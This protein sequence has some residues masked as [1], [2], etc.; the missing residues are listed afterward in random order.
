MT[1]DSVIVLA[2]GRASRLGGVDKPLLVIDGRTLLQRALDAAAGAHPRIVVGPLRPGLPTDLVWVRETPAFAGP[3]ANSTPEAAVARA[4][5]VA[6]IRALDAVAH[7]TPHEWTLVLA[8]DLVD[9]AAAVA[10]LRAERGA[11]SPQSRG[12]CLADEAG[13]AQWLTGFYRTAALREAAA[14]LPDGGA[15]AP[16]RALLGSLEPLVV[17]ASAHESADI[18]TWDDVTRYIH[19]GE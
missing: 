5:L 16:A 14:A 7:D 17:P 19:E 9:P 1:G 13:R 8:A 6:G 11:A 12:L 4:A 3:A 18:D 15:D 10:R 2:G